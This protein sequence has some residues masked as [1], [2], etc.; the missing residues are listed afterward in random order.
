MSAEPRSEPPS[1]RAL[2]LLKQSH[3]TRP[4]QAVGLGIYLLICLGF[5]LIG[6]LSVQFYEAI[7]RSVYSGLCTAYYLSLAFG[8]WAVWRRYSLRI[9]KLELSAFLGQFFFQMA[10]SASFFALHEMLLALA[11]LLLL[12]INTLVAAL[13]FWK[14]ERLSGA[15]LLFPVIWVFCL[16]WLNMVVC[17]LA[18]SKP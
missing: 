7:P 3:R 6:G 12:W 1:F 14:K 16:V 8:M 10:W 5:E 9:L 15:L 2:R 17:I 13:L 4:E 11:A 18:E